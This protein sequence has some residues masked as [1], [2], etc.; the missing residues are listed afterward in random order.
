MLHAPYVMLRLAV[1]AC[2]SAVLA[3]LLVVTHRQVGFWSD[4][5]RLFRHALAVTGDT[6]ESCEN[7]GD[8]LLHRERYAEAEVQF[9]KVLSMDAKTFRQTP[10]ELARALEKQGRIDEAI[11]CLN[12]GIRVNED[13]AEAMNQLGMLLAQYRWT[14]AGALPEAIEWLEKAHKLAPKEWAATKNL[15]WIYATCPNRRFRDGTKAVALASQAC[16]L[17]DWNNAACRVA[18]A[19]GYHETGDR[20]CEIEELRAALALSPKDKS[21]TKKLD[22]AVNGRP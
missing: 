2:F 17:T 19:D 9:R 13:N 4:S 3:I 14:T 5:V 10:G 12:D 15:A 22:D 20:Q 16:E 1:A 21:I 18:L 8:G 6:P 7:L 11:S